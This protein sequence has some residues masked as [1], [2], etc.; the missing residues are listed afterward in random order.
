MRTYQ[1]QTYKGCRPARGEPKGC[2]FIRSELKLC[3]LMGCEFKGNDSRETIV[4]YFWESKDF[5][6]LVGIHLR[7][8]KSCLKKRTTSRFQ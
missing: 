3:K 2:E 8:E 6:A 5:H 1:V 4:L 7:K